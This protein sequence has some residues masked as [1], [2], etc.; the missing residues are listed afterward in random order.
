[1][2]KRS[3]YRKNR[4]GPAAAGPGAANRVRVRAATLEP[5]RMVRFVKQ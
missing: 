1:M 5:S 4:T 2:I 3:A